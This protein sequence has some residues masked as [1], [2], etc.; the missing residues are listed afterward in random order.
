MTPTIIYASCWSL[1]VC[2]FNN[3]IINNN[4]NRNTLISKL[5]INT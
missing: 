2:A 1:F 5:G 3:N 4:I